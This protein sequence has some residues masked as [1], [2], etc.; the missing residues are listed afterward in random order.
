MALGTNVTLTVH[1]AAQNARYRFVA[2]MTATGS[3]A[4]PGIKCALSQ[5]IGTEPSVVWRPA[6]GTYRLTAYGPSGQTETDTLSLTY[7]VR[8]GSSM[9]ASSQT[10]AQPGSVTLVLRA[11]DL[12]AGHVYDWWAHI[13]W[14]PTP[15]GGGMYASPPQPKTRTTQTSG[16]L[17]TYPTA[18]P[19]PGSI[20]ATVSIH[21]GSPCEI[22]AVGATSPS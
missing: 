9:L 3:G 12:G 19:A 18:V 10:P 15:T 7:V 17:A 4:R 11:N 1:G 16:P 2:A 13:V 21:R 22:V 8:P 20:S 14:Q 6:S 5:T